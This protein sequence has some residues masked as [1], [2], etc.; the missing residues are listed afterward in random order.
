MKA[1]FGHFAAIDW[2]GAAGERH[3]GIALAICAEGD[4]A[5]RLVRAG[6]RWSRG[7][8]LDWLVGEMPKDTLAGLDLPMQRHRVG[9]ALDRVGHPRAGVAVLRQANQDLALV[10]RLELLVVRCAG[11]QM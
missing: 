5:P 8:V 7:E 1:R 3:K 9:V 11:D 4:E 6:H 2:S 10:T